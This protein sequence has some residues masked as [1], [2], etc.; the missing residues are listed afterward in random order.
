MAYLESNQSWG[1][2][3][4]VQRGNLNKILLMSYFVFPDGFMLIMFF[5]N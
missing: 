2:L 1:L 5:Q 4:D 3:V